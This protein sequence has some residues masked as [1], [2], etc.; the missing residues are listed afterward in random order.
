[1]KVYENFV[2]SVPRGV[3]RPPGWEGRDRNMLLKLVQRLGKEGWML[4]QI[5][6]KEDCFMAFVTREAQEEENDDLPPGFDY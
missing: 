3:L 2:Y 4:V 5:I 1:M 6:E